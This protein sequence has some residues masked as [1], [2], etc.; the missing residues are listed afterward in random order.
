MKLN[1]PG[2]TT[3]V[4]LLVHLN[5]PTAVAA[6]ALDRTRVIY[7]AGDRA[8]SLS[9]SNENKQL[10]FLAQGWLTDEQGA[11]N[12]L[13][14]VVLP[15]VQRV[16]PGERS[17]IKIQ[18]LPA[19][20]RLPQDR[21]SL[22]YFN[23]R[24]IPPRSDRPN[25]LQIALQTSIKLFYRPPAIVPGDAERLTP[26]QQQLM[27]T[28]LNDRYQIDNPTPYFIT[29]VDARSNQNNTTATGFA[30]LMI[31][32]RDKSWLGGSLSSLGSAP[33]LT[34]VND[35]GGRVEL[36]F[37]CEADRCRVAKQSQ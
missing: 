31:P 25:T 11:K 35:Y 37:R 9:I 28:R 24:E 3:V 27:L 4:A 21:E 30:P 10:P 13:P 29:L 5:I 2:C 23:L 18:A 16:E 6:I 17:Q 15:P 7:N 19:A 22:F 33:V 1:L 20:E 34:Y 32:P 8:I 26:W 36:K 14:L 12:S